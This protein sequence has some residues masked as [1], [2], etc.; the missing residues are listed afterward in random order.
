MERVPEPELM[1]DATQARAYANAD[2]SEPHQAFVNNFIARFPHSAP[3]RVI[4]LGCGSADISLRFAQAFTGC[5]LLGI[6]GSGAMLKLAQEAVARAGLGKRIQLRW[7]K[8]PAT[9]DFRELFDTVISNS[10][11]H[12]LNDP[13]VLWESVK[14]FGLA[15]AA[16]FIMDLIRPKSLTL[17]EQLVM[18]YCGGEPE[19][20][21]R[22]FYN[23]LCAAYRPE[24]IRKL[25]EQARLP[26]EVEVVSDRHMIIYGNLP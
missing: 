1:D 8:L 15:G 6:D 14:K 9:N 23:S 11:L 3:Q 21:R 4:D 25:L 2:F 17:T 18:R 12:H 24:E 13:K 16:V 20:L 7:M 22:D 5:T 26:F 10:L 19:I